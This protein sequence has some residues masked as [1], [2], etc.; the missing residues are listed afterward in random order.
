M[1][2][3]TGLGLA[4]VFGIVKQ[5]DGVIQVS[6]KV[7]QGTTFRIYL[8]VV[9]RPAENEAGPQPDPGQ[10]GTETILVAEDNDS[11]RD[12][13]VRSLERGGYTVYSAADGEEAV[14]VFT[15]HANEID[16][17]FL[18]VVMPKMNGK[19]ALTLIRKLKPS[20]AAVFSSG[21]DPEASEDGLVLDEGVGMI[22]KPH[23]RGVMLGKIREVLDGG[24]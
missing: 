6:S 24:K 17:V 21:Y 12:L 19:K 22:R 13:T 2:K 14:A 11:V 10:G 20:V 9:N 15:K 18:D 16:L 5:H 4:T 7:G 23:S 3:G 1:G 8:P